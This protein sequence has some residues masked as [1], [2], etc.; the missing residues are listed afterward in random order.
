[1]LSVKIL[2]AYPDIFP[3]TLKYSVIGNALKEKI[4]SLDVRKALMMNLLEE[5][6]EW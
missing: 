4:W 3:G 5:V 1:V 2:T 6:L